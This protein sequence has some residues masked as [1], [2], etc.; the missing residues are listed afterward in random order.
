MDNPISIKENKSV[1]KSFSTYHKKTPNP[2]NFP[3]EFMQTYNSINLTKTLVENR[4]RRNSSQ[5]IPKRQY[6]LIPKPDKYT[7]R[8]KNYRPIFFHKYI[9]KSS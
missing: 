4:I 6:I 8:K 1:I 5:I 2:D 3:T 7:T 9:C